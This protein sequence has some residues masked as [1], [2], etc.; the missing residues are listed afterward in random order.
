MTARAML[1]PR[2]PW[3]D[4]GRDTGRD[5]ADLLRQLAHRV[6]RLGVASRLDPET[7]FLEKEAIAVTL[8]QVARTME[9]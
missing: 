5:T 4:T 3:R 7:V 2:E 1:R 9:K 6:T 8:R